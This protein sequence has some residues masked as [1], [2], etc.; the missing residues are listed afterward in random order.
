MLR[1]HENDGKNEREHLLHAPEEEFDDSQTPSVFGTFRRSNGDSLSE[2]PVYMHRSDDEEPIDPDDQVN[3]L[4]SF[5]SKQMIPHR[6][7][8]MLFESRM[9]WMHLCRKKIFLI[10]SFQ[11]K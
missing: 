1:E 9:T 4:F 11:T 2:D 5:L 8:Q 3:G 10:L 6:M 7:F